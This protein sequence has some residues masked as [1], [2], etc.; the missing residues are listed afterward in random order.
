MRFSL[1]IFLVFFSCQ[2]NQTVKQV[3]GGTITIQEYDTPPSK[4]EMSL[5]EEDI[6]TIVQY[7]KSTAEYRNTPFDTEQLAVAIQKANH[8]GQALKEL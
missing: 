4:I 8:F 3:K 2:N 7:T 6:P 1:I 5:S